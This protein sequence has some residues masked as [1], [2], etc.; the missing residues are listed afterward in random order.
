MRLRSGALLAFAGFTATLLAG[1]GVSAAVAAE[2]DAP[3]TVVFVVDGSGS[4]WG[5]IGAERRAKLYLAVDAVRQA[6]QPIPPQTRLGLVSFGHRRKADCSDVEVILPP[7][8]RDF[9]GLLTPLEKLNPKGKG[10]LTLALREA[11]AA[12]AGTKGRTGIILIHDGPDNCQHDPCAVAAEI[13]A[14]SPALTISTVGLALEP[15]DA[16]RMSCVAKT[17]GGR[18]FNATDASELAAAVNEALRLATLDVSP[19]SPTP[20]KPRGPMRKDTPL[21]TAI[22]AG[23]P[24]LHLVA[25]LGANEEA[26]RSP[27][28]W[29]I[30]KEGDETGQSTRDLSGAEIT[31]ELPAG[32]YRVVARLGLAT[33]EATVAVAPQG[34]TR[35]EVT[36]DA[37]ILRAATKSATGASIA[38]GVLM[39]I[40]ASDVRASQSRKGAET[41]LWISRQSSAELVV[42]TGIYRI[43]LETGLASE[44]QVVSVTRGGLATAELPLGPGRLELATVDKDGG[45]PLDGVVY[46][47]AVDDQEALG[48][49][50]E[51]TRTAAPRPSITLPAGTYYV[52]A[53]LGAA[54]TRQHLAIGAGDTVKQMLV[55]PM[56]RLS[57]RTTLGSKAKPAEQP[58]LYRILR[59]DGASPHEVTRSTS[60]DPDF[61]LPP[62]RYRVEAR[63]GSQNAGTEQDVVLASGSKTES[64]V[65]FN[66]SQIA[67]RLAGTG[68]GGLAGGDTYWEIAHVDSRASWRTTEVEPKVVLAPGRYTVRAE[69][70]DRRFK[71]EFT[72]GP[73]EQRMIEVGL[74]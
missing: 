30:T 5:Q 23:P 44:E 51:F 65:I 42:P 56:A 10:P 58:V 47:I 71:A 64:A 60:P 57:L 6:L 11:A 43:R 54:E 18:S 15:D 31:E 37:G 28:A 20:A 34:E 39:T 52:T 70:R 24:R 53:R 21:A 26:I 33:T 4:M 36:F 69:S 38:D 45:D 35:A 9:D 61:V 59:L 16:Q 1:T 2:A 22:A 62:G 50:R 41:P 49:R 40:S 3:P 17:T 13:A 32:A 67:L 73:G 46:T 66:A 29:R 27:I 63:L 12:A 25:L 7:T 68:Y 48:G 8:Q 19:P 74:E 55:L 72:V 14:A